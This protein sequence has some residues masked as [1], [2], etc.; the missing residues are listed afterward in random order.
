MKIKNAVVFMVLL[1][2]QFPLSGGNNSEI[3]LVS[4]IFRHGERTASGFYPKDPHKIETFYP[5]GFGGLTNRGKFMMFKLGETLREMYDSLLGNMELEE[6][7]Y[8]ASTNVSR[9]IM[10]ASLVLSGMRPRNKIQKWH[11]NLNLPSIPIDI[12]SGEDDSVLSPACKTLSRELKGYYKNPTTY[13]K[14]IKPQENFFKYIQN[15]TGLEINDYIDIN[16]VYLI[17]KG[18]DDYGLQL[19]E[20]TKLVY[21]EPIHRT[22]S[23]LY[24]YAN[25]ERKFREINSGYLMRKILN[26]MVLKVTGA[27]EPKNRKMF[28]YSG[29]DKTVGNILSNLKVYDGS[30]PDYGNTVI[31]ELHHKE[32]N[33]FVK[34]KY[35]RNPL[36]PTVENL[37]LP[38]CETLCLL[39]K[40][41]TLQEEN[42]YIPSSP[43][44]ICN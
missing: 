3:L 12:K 24:V 15:K 43:T 4:A 33:Y 21:P 9:T 29:H 6:N 44:K 38:Y 1:C 28:L 13:E 27:L 7:I 17:L 18:E 30:L 35:L 22:A 20:W 41:I 31:F 36:S 37:E 32:G 16:T 42:D 14:Y 39:E 5:I 19:P 10:S 25:L 26:D 34:L 2:T 8:V 23:F 11:P 40:F